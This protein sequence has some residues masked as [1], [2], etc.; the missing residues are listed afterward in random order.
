MVYDQGD[1][2]FISGHP[3][4]PTMSHGRIYLG[5]SSQ[6]RQLRSSLLP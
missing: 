4:N 5:N 6:E 1:K 2:R 3:V